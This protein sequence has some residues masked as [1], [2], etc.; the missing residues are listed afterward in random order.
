MLLTMPG[1]P[2]IYYGYEIGMR[3]LDGW[4]DKEGAIWRGSCR[5]PMQWAPGPKAGFSTADPKQFYLPID[6]DPHRPTV[7]GEEKDKNSLLNFTRALIRLRA[8]EPSL[9]NLGGF[10]VLYAEAKSYP[11]VYLRSGG[12]NDFVVVLNPSEKSLVWSDPRMAGAREE[13]AQ[14]A[15]LNG[16]RVELGP[17]SFGIYRL[18]SPAH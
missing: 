9:G 15:R 4:P 16:R 8:R 7:A 1:V 2:F 13:L 3:N 14:N 18:K 11:F 17:V 12:P 10:S 6:P 5:S